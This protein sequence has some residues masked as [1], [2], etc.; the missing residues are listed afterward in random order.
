[1]NPEEKDNEKV[2]KTDSQSKEEPLVSKEEVLERETETIKNPLE[3]VV[4]PALEETPLEINKGEELYKEENPTEKMSTEEEEE[5]LV[6][7]DLEKEEHQEKEFHIETEKNEPMHLPEIEIDNQAEGMPTEEMPVFPFCETFI[8]PTQSEPKKKSKKGFVVGLL[9]V[10]IV[11]ILVA[12]YFLLFN[13]KN[14]FLAAVNKEYGNIVNNISLLSNNKYNIAKNSTLVTKGDLKISM[15]A[16]AKLGE[17]AVG[18]S[19]EFNQVNGTYEFGTDYKNKKASSLIS[20]KYG[21]GEMLELGTYAKESSLYIELKDLFDKYI[22]IPM[23]EY[24]AL[25]E[26]PEVAVEDARTI[27]KIVKN[28]FLESLDPKDFKKETVTTKVGNKEQKV[29]KISYTLTENNIHTLYENVLNKLKKNKTFIKL[30]TQYTGEK[31]N[32]IKANM[33]KSIKNYK[34]KK[35]LENDTIELNVYTDGILNTAVKY[36]IVASQLDA[37][38]TTVTEMTFVKDKTKTYTDIL[39]NTKE[40]I[41]IE[42]EKQSDQK[43]VLTATYGDMNALVNYTKENGKYTIDYT[44]TDTVNNNKMTGTLQNEETKKDSTYN[45]NTSFTLNYEIAGTKAF[46]MKMASAYETKIGEKVEVPKIQKS[47]T[48][49]KLTNE[50]I[51]TILGNIMLNPNFMS[52]ATHV[53][54]YI[55]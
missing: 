2:I 37:S 24:D 20:L 34:T 49:D 33:E 22:E 9:I 14:L 16:D 19:K 28:A 31:Q 51:N 7:S 11:A 40:L 5:A 17:S 41:H 36:G 4:E 26:N 50:N 13:T 10:I 1:M 8:E 35:I 15:E 12:I 55:Y 43:Y 53:L 27:T 25:Y 6:P 30:L 23:K 18:I 52:F 48:Y 42:T 44:I 54:A 21:E 39:K 32:T 29:T 46:T 45:G 47:I 3:G 38:E